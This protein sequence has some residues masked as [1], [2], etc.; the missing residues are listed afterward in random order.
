MAQS[1]T[2][3]INGVEVTVGFDKTELIVGEPLYLSIKVAN[4]TAPVIVGTFQSTLFFTQGNSVQVMIQPPGELPYRYN[5]TEQPDIPYPSKEDNIVNGEA[6]IHNMLILYDATQPNGYA[7]S[8]P[9]E[10]FI[11]AKVTYSVL[12]DPAK[13][14]TEV[15]ATRIVVR[16][17]EDKAAE[18]FKLISTPEAAKALHMSSTTNK[19]VLEAAR[20]IAKDYPDTPYAP[21]CLFLDGA[22]KMRQDPPDHKGAL[23]IFRDFGRRY[24]K[25]QKLGDALFDIALCH[26][27]MKHM[28]LA[29]AWYF[30]LMDAVPTY[31]LLRLETPLAYALYYEPLTAA[32]ERRWWLYEQPWQTPP[33]SAASAKEQ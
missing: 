8:K 30:H 7:F 6:M 24:P 1:A 3:T 16:A 12:R 15:P 28:D 5:G 11:S 31:E 25:N 2:N 23:A 10:Y 18:A 29:R 22:A 20:K 14:V 17:A 19:S 13:N 33:P 27:E 4:H 21:L 9:G 32:A 26:Y